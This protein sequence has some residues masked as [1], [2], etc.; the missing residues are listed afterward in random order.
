MFTYLKW[1][2]IVRFAD[3]GGIVDH[4][5]KLIFINFKF[6]SIYGVG[7]SVYSFLDNRSEKLGPISIPWFVLSGI[8]RGPSVLAVDIFF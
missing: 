6:N 4:H 3:S 7:D 1:E 5:S 2:A 8:P